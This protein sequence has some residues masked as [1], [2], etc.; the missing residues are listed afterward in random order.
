MKLYITKLS[1]HP[2]L[3]P[4]ILTIVAVIFHPKAHENFNS[5]RNALHKTVY[6]AMYHLP[7][8]ILASNLH[9]WNQIDWWVAFHG[10]FLSLY[11]VE[12]SLI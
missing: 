3:P 12:D 4:S 6:L 9:V 10:G 2:C 8:L 7:H 5:S 11:L 1:S